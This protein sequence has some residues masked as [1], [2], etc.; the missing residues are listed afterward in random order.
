MSELERYVTEK[1]V[2]ELTNIPCST[3]RKHRFFGEGMPYYKVNKTVRYLL[4][5][6][7]DFM[8]SRRIQPRR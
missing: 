8:A 1:T 5:D 2:S 7:H 4:R 6:V 3:L